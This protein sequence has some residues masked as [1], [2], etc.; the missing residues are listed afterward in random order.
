LSEGQLQLKGNQEKAEETFL[1]V[2]VKR[3]LSSST[4]A[5]SKAVSK[6]KRS[7]NQD[8]YTRSEKSECTKAT[9]KKVN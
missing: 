3:E 6:A 9:D 7:L 5:T 1:R 4:E 8:L 2:R